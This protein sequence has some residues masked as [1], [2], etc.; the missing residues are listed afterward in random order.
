MAILQMQRVLEVEGKLEHGITVLPPLCSSG[1]VDIQCF[2]SRT[3]VSS[4]DHIASQS[5]FE[6]GKVWESMEAR[7]LNKL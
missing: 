2:F 1:F 3:R 5:W 7:N 4:K 6:G